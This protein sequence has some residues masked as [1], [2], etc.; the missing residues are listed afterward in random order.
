MTFVT[1]RFV[2]KAG[3]DGLIN[4][5]SRV[6]YMNLKL[7]TQRSVDVSNNHES[8]RLIVL[9]VVLIPWLLWEGGVSLLNVCTCATSVT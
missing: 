8:H 5:A 2:Q 3:V 1:S 6:L 7:R 4:N 9:T